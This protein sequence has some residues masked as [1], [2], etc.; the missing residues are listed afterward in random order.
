MTLNRNT[1]FALLTAFSVSMILGAWA[2][3]FIGGL[4]PCKLCYYQRYP[5]WLAAGAGA[6]ALATSTLFLAYVAAVGAAASGLIGLYHAGVEQKW[7][8]G[9]STCTSGDVSNMSSDDL[10]NQIMAAPIVRCDDIPW[11]MFGLS[12][13]S[14]NAILSLA[15]AALWIYAI[16]RLT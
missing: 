12:M 16:K 2:F 14:Y 6:L 15:A 5:H 4:A 1:A 8:E 11:Q 7:W 3:E 9:P 13:A 10:F